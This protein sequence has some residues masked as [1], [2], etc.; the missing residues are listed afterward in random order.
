M[1][2]AGQEDSA[3]R[4]A[5]QAGCDLAST[6]RRVLPPWRALQQPRYPR[7][8]R[9]EAGL[10]HPGQIAAEESELEPEEI[11]QI[12]GTRTRKRYFFCIMDKKLQCVPTGTF[13][14]SPI[15]HFCIVF[16]LLFVTEYTN[17]RIRLTLVTFS[18][19]PGPTWVWGFICGHTDCEKYSV[20]H[21]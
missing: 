9:E 6:Q 7:S 17:L 3:R 18:Y 11:Y 4:T 13:R 21:W 10:P 2:T 14:N 16:V 20:S 5:T 8:G 1:Q 19:R 12:R 15:L